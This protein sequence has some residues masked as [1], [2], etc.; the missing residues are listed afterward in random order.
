MYIKNYFCLLSFI[1]IN[2]TNLNAINPDSVYNSNIASVTFVRVGNPISYPIIELNS[3][4][5]VELSFDLLGTK[6]PFLN[7][8]LVHCNADWTP[9]ELS[10][11]EYF[12]SFSEEPI[13]DVTYSVN[14]LRPYTHYKLSFPNQNIKPTKSGNYML[15][16]Y[17]DN[18]QNPLLTRKLYIYENKVIVNAYFARATNIEDRLSKQELNFSISKMGYSINAMNRLQVVIKQNGRSDNMVTNPKP[19]SVSTE[20]INYENTGNIVFDGASEFRSFDIKSVKYKLD[21]VER[22]QTV[23]N[24]V[25]AWLYETKSKQYGAYESNSDIN[26]KFLIKTEDWDDQLQAEYVFVNFFL[27]SA[28]PYLDGEIYVYGG[29]TDWK[30]MPYAKM[31]YNK[32]SG[33]YFSTILLK[34]GYYNYQYLFVPNDKNKPNDISRIEGNH[35]ETKNDYTIFVYYREDGAIADKLIAVKQTNSIQRK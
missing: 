34:Q 23:N 6:N 3:S 26:G 9:S 21:N 7:Y 12:D 33:G 29:L 8:T 22:I 14:T 32:E 17:E 13:N 35:W 10:S 2:L 20:Q 28:N 24:D 25:V 27:K 19:M 1:I 31:L 11:I 16:V 5:I 30:I 18:P 4:D 15:I